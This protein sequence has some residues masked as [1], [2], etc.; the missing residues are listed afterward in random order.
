M[1]ANLRNYTAA[2]FGL[3][4]VIRNVPADAWGNA[5]G[6]D[7]WTARELTGHAI[8]VVN[9]VA[10]RA[11]LGELTDP[12]VN[13]GEFA[14]HDIYAHWYE[15]RNRVLE[16]LDQPG[17]LQTEVNHG[18]NTVTVDAFLGAMLGDALIHTWDL[19]KATGGDTHLD[20]KLVAIVHTALLSRDPAVLRAPGR[21][22]PAVHVPDS[23]NAVTKLMAFA[24]RKI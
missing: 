16:A 3:D 24:G 7:G 14:G 18:G 13:P 4:N 6:C 9:N 8:G 1:S 20:A 21:F 19:A 22:G 17:V 12:F 11:G 15:I 10:A 23:A 5:T 2:L